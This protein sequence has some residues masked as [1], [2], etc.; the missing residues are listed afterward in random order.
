MQLEKL[1]EDRLL[2]GFHQQ[3]QKE[4]EKAWHDQHIKLR[5]FKVNDLVLL[6][7]RTFDKFPGK[8]WM[9]WLGPYVIK[10]IIDGGAFQLVKLNGERFHGRVNGSRLKPYTRDP[11]K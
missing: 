7:D 11:A 10:E 1:E 3:A 2:V 9:H 5:T 4:R 8:F 6:Y